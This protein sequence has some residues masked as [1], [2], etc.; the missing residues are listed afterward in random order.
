MHVILFES[1]Q[2]IPAL[3]VNEPKKYIKEHFEENTKRKL[4]S[5]LDKNTFYICEVID[6]RIEYPKQ[7]IKKEEIT[8]RGKKEKKRECFF[9]GFESITFPS[10]FD[11][12]DIKPHSFCPCCGSIFHKTREIKEEDL[13]KKISE[14]KKSRRTIYKN[15]YKYRRW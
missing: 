10:C 7:W 14:P 1:N 12:N 3:Y 2:F 8:E 15:F 6:G 4:L 13:Y 11:E 5:N 9:C